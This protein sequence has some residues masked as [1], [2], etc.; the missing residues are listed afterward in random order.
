VL[1]APA[2]FK[3][4]FS[5]TKG[6]FVVEVH[7]DWAPNGADRFYNLVNIGFYDDAAFFRVG[8]GFMAQTGL[9]AD[10]AV[11]AKWAGARIPDDQSR[12]S[13]NRGTACFAMAGPNTRTTQIFFNTGNNW[14]L[15]MQ[16]FAPFGVIVDSVAVIDGLYSD[17]GADSPPRGNAPDQGRLQ[18]EGNAYLKANFPNLDYIKTARLIQ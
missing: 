15:D 12:V 17:Y 13:N 5:T 4:R 6:D 2:V 9:H 11:S 3:A 8:R 7:R 18:L 1:Q 10:P 16:G 14:I